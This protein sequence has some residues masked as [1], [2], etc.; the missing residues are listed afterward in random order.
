MDIKYIYKL[1]SE[2]SVYLDSGSYIGCVKFTLNG[3]IGRYRY[4]NSK[5][6][7][8]KLNILKD[9]DSIMY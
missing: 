9:M 1:T 6:F 4:I 7:G 2:F 8:I 5:Y 3:N